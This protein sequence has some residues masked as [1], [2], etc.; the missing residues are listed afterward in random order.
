MLFF[1]HL[2]ARRV[3]RNEMDEVDKTDEM[4]KMDEMDKR[5]NVRFFGSSATFFD[6]Y[7][8]N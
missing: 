2:H 3:P 8:S 5:H 6:D 4:D 7:V 1:I